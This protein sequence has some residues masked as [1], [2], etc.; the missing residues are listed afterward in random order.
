MEVVTNGEH[1]LVILDEVNEAVQIGMLK[2]SLILDLIKKK[3]D[4]V[5]LVLTGRGASSE[6]KAAA[7]LVTEMRLHKHYFDKG[8]NARRGIEY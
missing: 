6:I 5:E 7:D 2:E 8:V 1:E 3:P 4:H